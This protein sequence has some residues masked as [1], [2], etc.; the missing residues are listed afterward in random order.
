[1]RGAMSRRPVSSMVR[2][3]CGMRPWPTRGRTFRPFLGACHVPMR[4]SGLVEVSFALNAVDVM[5]RQAM[6]D[7]DTATQAMFFPPMDRCYGAVRAGIMDAATL[8][9]QFN[10]QERFLKRGGVICMPRAGFY[11]TGMA[12]RPY[13]MHNWRSMKSKKV[14]P[15]IPDATPPTAFAA[16]P[17]PC[18]AGCSRPTTICVQPKTWSETASPGPQARVTCPRLF[19]S[20]R[21]YL[22]AICVCARRC[23][24][25]LAEQAKPDSNPGSCAN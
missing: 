13:P 9:S 16:K 7:R 21:R 4:V 15:T 12:S 5:H 20:T 1:M 11:R 22:N 14:I 17:K 18:S 24:S 2:N 10:P 25:G 6:R 23:C 19:A 8:A 3:C